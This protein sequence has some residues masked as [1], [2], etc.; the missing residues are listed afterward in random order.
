MIEVIEHLHPEQI[1]SIV[2]RCAS[3][4]KPDGLLVITT[5][6]YA[7]LWPLLEWLVARRSAVSYHEQH[8]TRFN[9]FTL[10]RRL[11][12][13]MGDTFHFEHATTMHFVA[14]YLAA[15]STRVS[16]AMA[17]AVTPRH[18]AWPLGAL[19]ITRLSLRND[20]E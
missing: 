19:I 10:R 7:S 1:R 17:S 9:R 4:L 18:W 2:K 6:N 8:V 14:P 5:P 12:G 3:V 16:D 20:G 11:A 13:L 15:L